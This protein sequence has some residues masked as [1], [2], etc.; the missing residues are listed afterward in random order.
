MKCTWPQLAL[1]MHMLGD[2]MDLRCSRWSSQKWREKSQTLAAAWP[3]AQGG[4]WSCPFPLLLPAGRDA[5]LRPRSPRG[6]AGGEGS[7]EPVGA[8]AHSRLPGHSREISGPLQYHKIEVGAQTNALSC[9]LPC[10]KR[11]F[12]M[13]WLELCS[14][15][16]LTAEEHKINS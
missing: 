2:K 8:G 1:L 14:G 15:A 13:A 6:R 9:S 11:S 7:V 10:R 3:A 4:C 12:S 16:D 5:G